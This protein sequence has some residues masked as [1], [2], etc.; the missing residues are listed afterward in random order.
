[1]GALPWPVAP[2][3][4]VR[5]EFYKFPGDNLHYF[6]EAKV[7]EVRPEGVLTL[8]PQGGT[9]HHVAKGRRVV[10]DHD[11]YVAF[12][13]GAWYSG[14]RTCGKAGCWSTTGTCRPQRSGRE[15]GFASMT[16]SWM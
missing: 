5:V 11:A 1:M 15:T 9:F 2:G 12:F 14:G 4:L 3:D 6:W 7:V 10:L 16:S 8:L 13:P